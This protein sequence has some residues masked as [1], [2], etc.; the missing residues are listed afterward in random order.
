M[1]EVA[2]THEN[3]EQYPKQHVIVEVG[4]GRYSDSN[5]FQSI[6]D[7]RRFESDQQ[8]IGID[9]G[10]QGGYTYDDAG[11]DEVQDSLMRQGWSDLKHNRPDEA[12]EFLQADGTKLPLTDEV[13]DE[14]ILSNVFGFGADTE[15]RP[16]LLQEANRVVKPNGIIVIHDDTSPYH[17]SQERMSAEAMAAGLVPD[18]DKML[19]VHQDEHPD[20]YNRLAQQYGF[21]TDTLFKN[22]II[23]LIHKLAPE[24][25]NEQPPEA[26]PTRLRWW[27]RT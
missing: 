11:S 9:L 10:V 6:A 27:K 3:F 26:A 1:S 5:A 18:E 21:D 17:A 12:I 19:L 2:Q 7:R 4:A 14:V 20:E 22:N 15:S 24:Q 16:A 25:P 13:A 23:W 8:Y